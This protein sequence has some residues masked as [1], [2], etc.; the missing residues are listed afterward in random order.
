MNRASTLEMKNK[1]GNRSK[2]IGKRYN[3]IKSVLVPKIGKNSKRD[4]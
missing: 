1:E 2:I 3:K 4:F